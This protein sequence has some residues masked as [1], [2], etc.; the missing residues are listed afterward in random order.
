MCVIYACGSVLP[1]KEE[2]HRGAWK[3][4]DGAGVGWLNAEKKRVCWKKGMKDEDEVLEFIKDE[5]IPF[6]L[7][8]HFRTASA[9]GASP[10]LT[11]PF[12][13]GKGVPVWLEGDANELL[14]HNG[15]LGKWEELVLQAGLAA[16]DPFPEGPWSDTRAMAW[17]THL[18]GPGVLRFI[19]DS[20]RVLLFHANPEVDEGEEADPWD[21]FSFWGS[22][23]GK[24]ADGFVQ[25]I[26][27]EYY[28]RG[29]V[30]VYGKGY[31]PPN[32]GPSGVVDTTPRPTTVQDAKNVWSIGELS[33]IL[34]TM[35]KE[36]K[37]ARAAAGV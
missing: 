15:H 13:V 27:T 19:H 29:G 11:H 26:S 23:V 18:K 4:D 9:G 7:A 31:T 6:P 22:W 21:H 2:L 5:K 36:L 12:P 28:N 30:V 16:K 25:S 32:Q 24:Q 10:F 35:E 14:F 20:S 37:D 33:E 8:I 17:L 3:N 34:T 1:D